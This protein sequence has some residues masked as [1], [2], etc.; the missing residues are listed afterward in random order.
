MI[1][2]VKGQIQPAQAIYESLIKQDPNDVESLIR[3][4]QTYES[5][6]AW[7]KAQSNYEQALRADP[8]SALV[9]NNLAWLY[10]NHGGNLDVALKLAQE[11]K[12]ATP[13]QSHCCRYPGVD[14]L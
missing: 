1:A 9:K 8:N 3:L 6:G 10:A 12:G 5:Q 14:L 4:G 7:D 13:E 11:A 2:V